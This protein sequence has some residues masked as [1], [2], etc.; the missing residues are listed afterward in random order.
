MP[1]LDLPN[2]AYFFAQALDNSGEVEYWRI[3]E[4]GARYDKL[5][6]ADPKLALIRKNI[7][8]A[9]MLE[10][11]YFFKG[12][13]LDIRMSFAGS[14][15]ISIRPSTLDI[16]GRISPVLMIFNVHGDLRHHVATVVNGILGQ[17]GRDLSRGSV[18]DVEKLQ[19]IL[20]LPR[21]VL[22]FTLFLSKIWNKING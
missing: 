8:E 6:M 22:L 1:S 2:C 11:F 17:M 16:D 19:R 10:A 15:L 20:N 13:T 12:E 18:A 7:D 3:S 9:A 4:Q 5:E 14:G 21:P